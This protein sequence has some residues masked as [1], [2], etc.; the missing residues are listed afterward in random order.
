[1]ASNCSKLM[2]EAIENLEG[3]NVNRPLTQAISSLSGGLDA[4]I[5]QRD[6]NNDG[7]TD[8]ADII[9][10]MSV[11]GVAGRYTNSKNLKSTIKKSLTSLSDSKYGEFLE[12]LVKPSQI[13]SSPQ[14]LN[15]P[16][17]VVA[18]KLSKVPAASVSGTNEVRELWNKGGWF[19]D[20][21]GS[22][23]VWKTIKVPKGNFGDGFATKNFPSI[24]KIYRD[25]DPEMVITPGEGGYFSSEF[26]NI[27]YDGTKDTALHEIQHAVQSLDNSPYLGTSI[28]SSVVK[29][30][31]E[32]FGVDAYTVYQ[33]EIGEVQ[34][35]L[36][37]KNIKPKNHPIIEIIKA[38]GLSLY[39]LDKARNL[40]GNINKPIVSDL[41]ARIR[42]GKVTPK[43]LPE[44]RRFIKESELNE[45][46]ASDA[47]ALELLGFKTL[48]TSRPKSS[49]SSGS[50]ILN[51]LETFK[52]SDTF[53]TNY[54]STA[55]EYFMNRLKFYRLRGW[56][57]KEEFDW[58]SAKVA[59]LK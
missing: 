28:K 42:T 14:R 53:N 2:K 59:R 29:Q 50:D 20:F 23:K 47:D 38:Q 9:I 57:S 39:D 56:I 4:S 36:A 44:I 41:I 8:I 17:E 54:G 19:L 51:E 48:S 31:S 58:G 40:F 24:D 1:M 5:N 6:Y 11:G 13:I 22:P 30:L 49:S 3:S 37:G 55:K 43:D 21:D 10:G 27:V 33:G 12:S 34:A 52:P 18:S 16:K 45:N 25:V 26:G 46:L 7:K 15:M 32:E 35:R